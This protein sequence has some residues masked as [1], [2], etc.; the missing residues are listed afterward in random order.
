MNDTD[1]AASNIDIFTTHTTVR[2]DV[3][4]DELISFLKLRKATGEVCVSL[5]QGG[6]RSINL[7][8]HTKLK[9]AERDN[10]RRILKI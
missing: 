1:F 3:S 4:I 10:V 9:D 6:V 5:N 8:E 7:V 2:A